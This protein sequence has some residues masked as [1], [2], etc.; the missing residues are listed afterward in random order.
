[1][2]ILITAAALALA[3][4]AAGCVALGDMAYRAAGKAGCENLPRQQASQ[5][6][7]EADRASEQ[8]KAKR[9]GR[10]ARL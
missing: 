10:P 1:M 6:R 5:C 7:A 8:A 4:S 9:E 2:R 3:A